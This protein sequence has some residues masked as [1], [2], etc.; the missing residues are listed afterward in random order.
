MLRLAVHWGPGS[1]PPHTTGHGAA[2][3]ESVPP[4]TW[5]PRMD[6]SRLLTLRGRGGEGPGRDAGGS[7]LRTSGQGR[8]AWPCGLER[9]PWASASKL[10]SAGG[11]VGPPTTAGQL[12]GGLWSS[13]CVSS[14]RF[15]GGPWQGLGGPASCPAGEPKV[16]KGSQAEEGRS[17]NPGAR[18]T[19]PLSLPSPQVRQPLLPAGE[20]LRLWSLV[21]SPACQGHMVSGPHSA[22]SGH[23]GAG[24]LSRAWGP[25]HPAASVCAT[26]AQGPSREPWCPAGVGPRLLSPSFWEPSSSSFPPS[27]PLRPW[28]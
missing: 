19:T 23:G 18:N 24:A 22:N 20:Q 16:R 26:Q 15:V 27:L 9:A 3:S 21:C 2:M 4:G 5:L 1:S 8:G 6:W 13:L 7:L 10:V 25:A 28:T 14:G 12:A 11:S 17:T